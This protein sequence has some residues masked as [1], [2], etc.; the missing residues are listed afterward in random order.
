MTV[1]YQDDDVTLHQGSSLEITEW[2]TADVLCTDPP[3][4]R[5]WRQGEL[6]SSDAH[7]GI[8]SDKDTSTRDAALDMWGNR[9]AI[10]FGDLMLTPPHGTKQTLVYRKAPDSGARGAMGGYRRDAEAIYLLG[11]WSSGIGG[12]TS[13][14]A[15]GA[16][17]QGGSHGSSARYQHPHAKPVD[18]MEAL[19]NACPPGVIADP[20][21]GA[22]STLVAAR[23]CGRKAIGVELE[24]KYCETIAKRLSQGVLFAFDAGGDDR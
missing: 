5:A 4:G 21:A 6:K 11:P 16:R 7:S 22:G 14:L 2:L 1:Y 18:V 19:I 13:I 24:E 10:V 15:T 17:L 20:F 23:N 8:A 9:L 12:R 3:Y